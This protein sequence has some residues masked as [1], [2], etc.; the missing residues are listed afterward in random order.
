[1][2][3]LAINHHY[4]R[5]G[6]TGRGIYPTTPMALSA[7]VERLRLSGW[8]FGDQSDLLR[9]LDGMAIDRRV[10]LLTFD[11]GLKEQLSA[12]ALLRTLGV[13]GICYVSTGPLVHRVVLDVH[14]LHMIRSVVDDEQLTAELDRRFGLS[15]R[16]FDDDLLAIQY[17]Y[18]SQLGRRLKYFLNFVIDDEQ[19]A[20]WMGQYF[21]V[22]F[23]SER[24]ASEALYMDAEDVRALGARGCIGSHGHLHLPLATLP[25]AQRK[26]EL[27][28]SFDVLLR[29]AGVAPAGISYP[30]GGQSAVNEEVCRDAGRA[31]YSYGFTMARGVN[32]RIQREDAL[33][34]RRIDVNDLDGY[35]SP[36][37]ASS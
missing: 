7:E 27:R 34:L 19:R 21:E 33:S 28:E 24:A 9:S 35:V 37:E 2:P 17:R 16:G 10:C 31:G 13:D 4:F 15:S 32:D 30:Y 5:S 23:G 8:S 11:D 36:V 29:I 14:K 12:I 26:E 22:L 20:A 6:G 25:P 18:D 3:I 1:M